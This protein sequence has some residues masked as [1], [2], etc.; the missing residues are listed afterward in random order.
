MSQTW[1]V[2]R[3]PFP[4]TDRPVRQHR[5]ALVI[6]MP[7]NTAQPDLLWV[8]MITSAANRGWPSDVTVSDPS[9]A[10]LPVPSLVRTA[11]VATIERRDAQRVGSLP[12]EDRAKVVAQLRQFLPQPLK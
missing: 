4:Y 11:K 5:P 9:A 6:A 2:V 8:L 1:D 10:G 3:V 7:T 12:D